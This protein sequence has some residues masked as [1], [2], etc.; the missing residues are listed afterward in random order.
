MMWI[1]LGQNW[2]QIA[3][4]AFEARAWDHLRQENAIHYYQKMLKRFHASWQ[5][6]RLNDAQSLVA[7]VI[8]L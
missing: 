2:K 3:M 8:I 4:G 6:L 1:L 5:D 7:G